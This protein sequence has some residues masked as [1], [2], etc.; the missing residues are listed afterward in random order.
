VTFISWQG[1]AYRC[2]RRLTGHRPSRMLEATWERSVSL[3][4]LAVCT[5]HGTGALQTKS[6]LALPNH[7]VVTVIPSATSTPRPRRCVDHLNPHQ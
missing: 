5:G 4:A 6:L 2:R 7:A 1:G 3:I